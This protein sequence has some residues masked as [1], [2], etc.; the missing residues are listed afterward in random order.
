MSPQ[1][2]FPRSSFLGG[3]SALAAAAV[4]RPA[5]AEAAADGSAPAGGARLHWLDGPP[6]AAVGCAFGVPWPRGTLSG[7]VPLALH[8]VGGAPVPVQ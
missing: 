6:A 8:A 5:S 7:N 1:S 3:V 4:A 2:P